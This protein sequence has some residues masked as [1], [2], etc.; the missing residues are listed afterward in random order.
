MTNNRSRG[1]WQDVS[2]KRLPRLIKYHKSHDRLWF[3]HQSFIMPNITPSYHHQGGLAEG[4][5]LSEVGAIDTS[6]TIPNY[7]HNF[8]IFQC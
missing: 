2:K 4:L 3:I 7:L 1:N 6:I 5:E 8:S